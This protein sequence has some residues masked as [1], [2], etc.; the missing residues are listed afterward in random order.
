MRRIIYFQMRIIVNFNTPV[1]IISTAQFVIR[2]R[3]RDEGRVGVYITHPYS[4]KKATLCVLCDLILSEGQHMKVAYTLIIKV[5]F[6]RVQ[7]TLRVLWLN[8]GFFRFI[9]GS[10][11][12]PTGTEGS[13]VV[14][15]L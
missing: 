8:V 3:C 2:I 13:F 4:K 12:C 11:M 1:I 9:K 6:R 7:R 15:V 10:L 14:I 5:F